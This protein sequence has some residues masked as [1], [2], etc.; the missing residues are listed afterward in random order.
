VKRHPDHPRYNQALFEA[1]M[2]AGKMALRRGDRSTAAR[3]L[4]AS[5]ESSGSA[6]LRYMP[7]D[8]TLARSLVDWGERETV[9]KFLDRCARISQESEKYKSW[10]ADIRKGI[11]PDLIPY[12]TGCGKEPC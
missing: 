6:D 8:M 12:R 11:N 1:N 9:A 7:I 5:V 2:Y 4:L 10:A 3:H